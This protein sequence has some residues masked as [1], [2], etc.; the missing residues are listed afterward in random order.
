MV[1]N[2]KKA[3]KPSFIQ[4]NMKLL[5]NLQQTSVASFRWLS[6]CPLANQSRDDDVELSRAEIHVQY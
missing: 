5:V 2:N 4:N 3:L 1:W 6:Q